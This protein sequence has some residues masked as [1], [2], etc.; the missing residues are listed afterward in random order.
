MLAERLENP[1]YNDTD[2]AMVVVRK[3]PVTPSVVRAMNLVSPEIMIMNY[4][5]ICHDDFDEI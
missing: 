1:R 4:Y 2:D 3:V 5:Q